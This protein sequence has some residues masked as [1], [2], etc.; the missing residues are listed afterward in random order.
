MSQP[1]IAKE[2]EQCIDDKNVL[3]DAVPS[4][5]KSQIRIINSLAAV[6]TPWIKSP[7][8]SSHLQEPIITLRSGRIVIHVKQESRTAVHGIV[9]DTSAS[10]LTLFI[11]P[12][13]VVELNNELT[14]LT[15]K[16]AEEVER[17]LKALSSKVSE[18]SVEIGSTLRALGAIDLALAKGMLSIN[19]DATEP[20]V[21]STKHLRIRQGRHP[22]LSGDVVP[23]DVELG[24]DF[25]T[26]VITGPN[27]GG[28]TVTLKTTGLF[29]LMTLAGFHLPAAPD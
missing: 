28:K 12:M 25:R 20:D 14:S 1:N 10:G 22:L 29:A 23:I 9:N 27:T 24:R 6:L 3:D 13:P 8:L 17:I 16:E 26:L 19:M 21:V 15:G 2:I 5:D 18:G 7:H 4:C 11:E